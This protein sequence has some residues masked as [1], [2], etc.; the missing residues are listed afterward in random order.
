MPRTIELSDVTHTR[1]VALMGPDDTTE[2]TVARLLDFYN[3]GAG[4]PGPAGLRA[5]TDDGVMRFVGAGTPDLTHTKVLSARIDGLD[6]PRAKWNT[7]LSHLAVTAFK[8][9]FNKVKSPMSGIVR[10][11]KTDSGYKFYPKANIS[12]Q[13]QDANDAWRMSVE[14]ANRIDVDI[15]VECEWRDKV[16]AA[17]PG[18]KAILINRQAHANQ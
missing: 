11:E 9:G 4:T 3:H 10:G 12:I 5:V 2:S 1:L 15:T 6:V 17:H 14:L 13:G 7:I 8:G 16:A 18:K